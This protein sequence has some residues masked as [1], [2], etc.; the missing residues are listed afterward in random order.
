LKIKN[1]FDI[2]RK[3]PRKGLEIVSNIIK[4]P[5]DQKGKRDNPETQEIDQFVANDILGRIAE[6]GF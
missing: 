3:S 2:L 1:S 4:N 5:E 6:G